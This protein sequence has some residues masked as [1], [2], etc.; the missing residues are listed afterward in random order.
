[1]NYPLA[2]H[3]ALVHLALS[4]R[5]FA[6][7][8]S[9]FVLLKLSGRADLVSITAGNGYPISGACAVV[10]WPKHLMNCKPLRCVLSAGL[11]TIH[12]STLQLSL[13]FFCPSRL[14]G[15]ID[16]KPMVPY[17]AVPYPGALT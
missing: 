5:I 1:M 14:D 12:V 8:H 11:L 17:D 15:V 4:A 10:E 16:S 2:Y 3:P 9:H 7:Y 6:L 13:G